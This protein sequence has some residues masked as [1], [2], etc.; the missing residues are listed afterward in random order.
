MLIAIFLICFAIPF[1]FLPT[2]VVGHKKASDK[3]IL[4]VFF[5]NLFA[6]WTG[7]GWFIALIIAGTAKPK[8]TN[9]E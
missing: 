9:Q 2:F 1:Y 5:I 4:T 7:I 6:G 8:I 3:V